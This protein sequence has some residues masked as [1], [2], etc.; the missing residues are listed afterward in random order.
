MA[1]K[2]F[3]E[4]YVDVFDLLFNG[5]KGCELR[6]DRP[7]NPYI[8]ITKEYDRGR[9]SYIYRYYYNSVYLGGESNVTIGGLEDAV[10][11]LRGK[12]VFQYMDAHGIC[13]KPLTKT[14]ENVVR[15]LGLWA[16]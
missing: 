13:Y 10:N 2:G 15:K 4:A 16:F 8:M 11:A 9:G 14:E 7:K 6:E 1:V 5:G 12:G 3:T